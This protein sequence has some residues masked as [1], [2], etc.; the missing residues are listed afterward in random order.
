MRNSKS[1]IFL[2]IDWLLVLFYMLFVSFGWLNIYATSGASYADSILTFSSSHGKQLYWIIFCLPLIFLTT[3]IDAKF[4]EKYASLL[5]L[6]GLL[7]LV[8]LFLLGKNIHG[9]TSWYVIGSMSVQPAE[10]VKSAVA[11]AMA[12][13][14]SDKHFKLSLFKNQL[15]AFILIFIPIVLVALQPD[16]GTAMIY[17]AF[18]LVL[19]R[20]GLPTS[21]LSISF[22]AI[23]L[24]IATL[25]FG[26]VYVLIFSFI[27]F[28]FISAHAFKYKRKTFKLNFPKF[29]VIFLISIA[30]IYSIQIIFDQVFEQRHRDR[31]DILLGKTEDVK[32]IGY[33][34]HQSVRT[35]ASGG[36]LGKG[37]MQGERTQ[38]SFVPEQ[39]TDYIFCTVGEEWGFLGS[40]AVVILF[41]L[42]ILRILYKSE[43]QKSSFARIYGIGVASIFFFHFAINIGMVLGILPTIGIPLPFFSYGGS[44]LWGFTILLF[45]FIRLDMN[46]SNEL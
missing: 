10:F 42:F 23:T 17:L 12:K 24:F 13:L 18:V 40:T 30:Y 43:K 25:Y 19:Y 28:C 22:L 1:N 29:I 6:T 37:F 11:L 15:Q 14:L 9:A 36:N 31:F 20:E 4:Y 46:K 3:V 44:S 35:I 38:G 39:Q 16:P 32:D 33:N 34:T 2:R 21:Y 7:T 41:L 26:Y 27:I 45:I 5:Y 8:G